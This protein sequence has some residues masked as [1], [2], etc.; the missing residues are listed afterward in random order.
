MV[1]CVD[2]VLCCARKKFVVAVCP[3]VRWAVGFGVLADF[4]FLDV[5]RVCV[6]CRWCVLRWCVSMVCV[7]MV[8]VEG[9]LLSHSL[10]VRARVCVSVCQWR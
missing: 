3:Y 7:T 1:C 10:C 5:A 8:C 6:S 2:G 9:L 4:C